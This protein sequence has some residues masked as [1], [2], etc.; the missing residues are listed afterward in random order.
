MN[1]LIFEMDPQLLEKLQADGC[2]ADADSI[3]PPEYVKRLK[4]AIHLM[5]NEAFVKNNWH[6]PVVSVFE[7]MLGVGTFV[8]KSHNRKVVIGIVL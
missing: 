3:C 7:V 5:G 1:T 2:E 8:R 6:A 4:E